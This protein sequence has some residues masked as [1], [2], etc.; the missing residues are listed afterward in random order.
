M[1]ALCLSG[2]GA[3]G[4]YQV[5][6]IKYLMGERGENYDI[7]TGTSVGALNAAYLAQFPVGEELDAAHGLRELW[8]G[9]DSSKVWREWYWGLLGLLPVVLPKWL[10]GKTSAYST[11]PLRGLVDHH[12]R[13][14]AILS[15]GKKLRVGAVDLDSGVR[16]VW[17]EQDPAHLRKA[18]LAS[19]AFPVFFEP[20]EIN[21]RLYTDAGVREVSPIEDAI[22][23]GAREIHLI[24]TRP[25]EVV[26]AFDR[27]GG[28]S[29][30]RRVLGVM[31]SEIERWDVRAVELYNA[32]YEARHPLAVGKSYVTLKVL[33]PE[34]DLLDNALDFNTTDIIANMGRGYADAK[35]MNWGSGPAVQ[36]ESKVPS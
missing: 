8:L 1:K 16:R 32:L 12:L 7:F 19:S 11:A 27:K 22:K 3:R 18:V 34:Q 26:G 36:S 31:E 4:A 28:L 9:L 17:D 15:S 13:P 30:G 23:A 2:G 20:V 21:G 10:G 5:G 35:A 33:R 6:A 29:L 25:M 24:S 14:R